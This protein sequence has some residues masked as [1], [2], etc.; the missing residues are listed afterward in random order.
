MSTEIVIGVLVPLVGGLIWLAFNNPKGYQKILMP[1]NIAIC[2][3]FML[4]TVY[5]MTLTRVESKI[6][7]A[8]GLTSNYSEI[9]MVINDQHFLENE[10]F[11]IMLAGICF[12]YGLM[13]IHKLRDDKKD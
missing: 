4:V 3:L 10:S 7:E 9:S 6:L 12:I 8:I 2:F 13:F 11:V 5:N 1:M